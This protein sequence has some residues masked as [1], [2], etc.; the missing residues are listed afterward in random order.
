MQNEKEKEEHEEEGRIRKTRRRTKGEY[1]CVTC[2]AAITKSRGWLPGNA[3]QT[4]HTHTTLN[5]SPKPPCEI[6]LRLMAYS[7]FR[8]VALLLTRPLI[9]SFLF[10]SNATFSKHSLLLADFYGDFNSMRVIGLMFSFR[11]NSR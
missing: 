8:Y 4:P 10:L 1:V 2:V 11:F 3:F 5:Q 9:P 6:P 7:F